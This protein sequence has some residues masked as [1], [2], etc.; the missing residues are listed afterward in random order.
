MHPNK[1]LLPIKELFLAAGLPGFLLFSR[2]ILLYFVTRGREIENYSSVDSSAIVQIVFTTAVFFI[3]CYLL[4]KEPYKR[5]FLF[6]KPQIFLLIYILVCFL[7]MLWT[8]NVFITGYRAFESLT[9]FILLSLLASNLVLRI[10]IQDIIEWL[11][12]WIVWNIFW[13]VALQIKFVGVSYLIWPFRSSRLETPILFFIALFLAQRSIFKYV[14]LAFAILAISNKVYFGIAFGLLGLF[15][16]DS[17]HKGWL[18]LIIISILGI[19]LFIPLEELLKETLFY[20]RETVSMASTSGRDKVWTVAWNGFLQNPILGYGYVSGEN[21]IL[22]NNFKGAISAHNFLFSGL[23]GTGLVGSLFLILYFLSAFKI[24]ISKYFPSSKWRPTMAST[25][26][27]S[28]IVSLTAPGIGGRIYGSW[29]PV[30]LVFTL[31]SA[32]RY[33]FKVINDIRNSKIS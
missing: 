6:S 24:S 25:F 32:L 15:F 23:L 16:G 29:I 27:M 8:P 3:S 33:K 13:S 22:Y 11:M 10:G 30:V 28:L 14:V 20:G 12:L 26:I 31:I 2:V 18:T 17:K 19:L 7:S 9:Y 21:T 5:R 1:K 4:Y